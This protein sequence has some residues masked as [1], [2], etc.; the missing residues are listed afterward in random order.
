VDDCLKALGI[1]YVDLITVPIDQRAQAEGDPAKRAREA[2]EKLRDAGKARFLGLTV[3]GDPIEGTRAG[4]EAG[5][6][7]V[8][9]PNYNPQVREQIDPLADRAAEKKIGMMAMKTMTGL[10]QEQW[11]AHL[12]VML[13]RK[14]LH[15]LLKSIPTMQA[16]D[17]LFQAVGQ[18]P[19]PEEVAA[20]RRQVEALRGLQCAMCDTCA[21]CPN[22]VRISDNLRCLQYYARQVGDMDYA[23]AAYYSLPPKARASSCGQCGVCEGKCPNGL[24][25]RKLLLEA[26]ALFA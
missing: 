8:I 16:L 20:D 13:G 26:T 6:W 3:H 9:M 18:V 14:S 23:K 21:G 11:T 15:S 17:D 4:V 24:P 12:K 1:D 19:T 22:G 10:S 5:V 7:D 2:Y 25:V